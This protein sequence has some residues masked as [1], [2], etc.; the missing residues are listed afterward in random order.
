MIKRAVFLIIFGLLI[1]SKTAGS[2]ASNG[3]RNLKSEVEIVN[4][5]A[6]YSII[7]KWE[8]PY[9]LEEVSGI[10]W[11]SN[12]KI[13]CIQDEDGIIFVYNLKTSTIEKEIEFAGDGDYEGITVDGKN[14]FVV[15]SDGTIY[16]VRDFLEGEPEVDKIKTGLTKKQNIESICVDKLGH[17][18]LL[19]VKDEEKNSDRYKGIYAYDLKNDHFQDKPLF[20]IDMKDEV[21]D[22]IDEDDPEKVMS[23]SG[24][25]IN[26]ESDEFYIV[27]G[28]RPK[29]LI[30]SPDGNAERIIFLDEDEFAQPEG[31]TFS[32]SG[33]LYISNEASGG[34]PNIL[35]IEIREKDKKQQ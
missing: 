24:I 17:R 25:A 8:L 6:D 20:R 18:L 1:I 14:A 15:R 30:M 35:E 26:P 2:A 28:R 29:I 22:E 3:D 10:T 31:I 19:G 33:K 11:L 12:D 16:E 27:D 9:E 32:P 4:K 5:F 34:I 7:K 13:C 23:P 21:F